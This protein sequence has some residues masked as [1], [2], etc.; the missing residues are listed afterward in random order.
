MTRVFAAKE[1]SLV[2]EISAHMGLSFQVLPGLQLRLLALP[3]LLMQLKQKDSLAEQS[4]WKA[5]RQLGVP[6]GS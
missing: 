4:F 5:T 1:V 6:Q 3:R 2:T